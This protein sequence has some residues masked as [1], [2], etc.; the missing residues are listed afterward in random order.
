MLKKTLHAI[1]A[2]LLDVHQEP[3]SVRVARAAESS[4]NNNDAMKEK[5]EALKKQVGEITAEIYKNAQQSG[6]N[7]T[8]DSKPGENPTG[9]SKPGENPTG[10]SKPGENPTGDSKPD[11][12]SKESTEEKTESSGADQNSSKNSSG[13]ASIICEMYFCP[14]GILTPFFYIAVLFL[15]DRRFCLCQEPHNNPVW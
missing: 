13:T 11:E 4:A 10:D 6:E 15:L 1:L 5:L 2:R 9:D 12:T 14:D 3:P 7:P 8:G